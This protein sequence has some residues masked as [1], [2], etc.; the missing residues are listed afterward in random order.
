MKKEFVQMIISME[1]AGTKV[2]LTPDGIA[3]V[4]KYLQGNIED[5]IREDAEAV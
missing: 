1:K 4:L 2:F 5:Y 3:E